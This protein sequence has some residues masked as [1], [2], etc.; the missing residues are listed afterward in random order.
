M[1]MKNVLSAVGVMVAV[2]LFAPVGAAAACDPAQD[3]V[4]SEFMAANDHTLVDEDGEF[5]D[6]IEVYNPCQPVVHLA[7]WS[8]TDDPDD[9]GKWH[10]PSVDLG[11]G[12]SVIV[13]A[14][15]KSRAVAGQPLH[16]NFKLEAAGEYLALVRPGGTVIA[17]EFAPQ[18]PPQV[19][20][21]SYGFEQSSTALLSKG[22]TAAWHV[23]AAGD[24][25][26]GSGWTAPAYDDAA[27]PAGPTG[28]GF[29]GAGS[30]GFDVTVYR[31]NIQVPDL[32]T[33]EAV[34]DDPATHA[35]MAHET[36]GVINYLNT[37]GS[38]HYG[39]DRT[40]PGMSIGTD[41]N[42]FVVLITGDVIIPAAGPW[43]FGVN[44]DDGFGLELSREPQLFTFSFP[45]PRGPADTLATFDLPEAGRYHL[46]LVMYERGGGSE[47]E[48]FAAQGTFASWTAGAF[49]LVGDTAAGGLAVNGLISEIGTDVGAAMRG[50]NASLWT[51]LDFNVPDPT[52]VGLLIL[53]LEYEDGVVAW[54]NGQQVAARNAPSPALWDSTALSDRPL[55]SAGAFER[56]DL[57]DFTGLLLPGTNVL[58]LQGLNN[59]AADP[60]FLVLPDLTS[61]GGGNDLGSPRFFTTPTPG[62]LNSAPGYPA[63][64]A[65]PQFSHPSA[66]FTTPFSLTLSSA[67]PAGV[68]RYTLDGSIPTATTGTVYTA[69][70][71]LSDSTRVTARVFEPG[72]APSRIVGRLYGRLDPSVTS[73][74]SNLPIV[75]VH[76]FGAA[77][78][79]DWLT[80]TLTS[81]I[82]TGAGGRATITDAA[83]F[84][85]PAGI[86]IRGSSSRSF[87][88]KQFALET[89]DDDH[90]DKDVAILDL[91]PESDWILY[92][93]YSEKGLIHN[94]MAYAWYNAL[95][96]YA[97]RTRFCELYLKTG[98][99]P[100]T[101]ADYAG[102]YVV[103][104]KIKLGP[105]RVNITELLPTDET[106]PAITGGYIIKKDRLDPGDSGFST[107]TGQVLAYVDPKE[108]EIT[109][110]QAAWL[111]GYLDQ[112]ESVLY[113]PGYADPVNGYA[114]YID[115]GS[116]IDHHILVELTKNI[117]GFRLSSFLSKDRLGKLDMGPI[118]D[119]N[120]SLGNANYLEGW[121]PTGWYHDMLGDGDYPYYRRLF[122]D[123]EFAQR[124]ADRWFELRRGP[125]SNAALLGSF[126]GA[127]ALLQESAPRNFQRWP[128]LGTYVWPNWYIGTTWA[129]DVAWTRQWLLDR[130]AWFDAQFPAPPA[131]S[132]PGG[133]VPIGTNLAITAAIGLIHYTLDGS[134]PRLPG[135]GVSPAAIVYSGPLVLTQPTHVRARSLASGVWSALNDAT[136]DPVPIAVVNEVL[137]VNLSTMADEHGDHDPWIEIYN[138]SAAVAALGGM[139]LTDDATIP[140]KWPIPAGTDLCGHERLLVWA[141]GEPSEGPLHAGFALSSSAGTISLF[142]AA[143][144][145]VNALARPALPPN[146]SYG[147]QPD[148]A[149]TFST[150]IH[151]TAATAN[152][153]NAAPIILNEYNGVLPTR[154]LSGGASDPYWGRILGNGGDWFELVV[155]QDHLDLRGFRVVVR[156]KAGIA[157]DSQQTLTFASN[158]ALSDLRSGTI[159]TVAADLM[160]D[161]SFNPSAGDFWINLRS[162]AS[163]DGQYI[164][165]LPFSVSNDNTQITLLDRDGVVVFGP[166]GEGINPASGVGNDEVLKLEADPGPGTT[167]A[168]EFRDGSSSTFGA[169]NVWSGG[170]ASQNFAALRAPLT[171][172]CSVDADCADGN[173]CTDD[174]C[175]GGHCVT[176]PNT[177]ACD[178]GN[179]C[180]GGDV[181]SGRVCRGTTVGSC[182]QSACAC[183]DSSVCTLDFCG[184]A[185]CQHSPVCALSGTV[186][187]YRDA[188]SVEPSA[189]G[190]PGVGIDANAD[191]IAD[192]LTAGGGVYAAGNWAG[193]SHVAPLS[194]LGA[195]RA[196]SENGA[197]SSFDASL[198]SRYA[199]QTIALSTNQKLAADVSGNGQVT[200]FDAARIAQFA[201]GLADHF[202]V[203]LASGSDWRFL[204]CDTYFNE[205]SHN[206]GAPLFTHDP[207][208]GPQ[209][210]DFYAVLFGDVSG[211]WQPT[212]ALVPGPQ[213]LDRGWTETGEQAAA[214]LDRDTA[215][216]RSGAVRPHPTRAPGSGPAVLTLEAAAG[217]LAR[218]ERRR[219]L[220]RID[221]ADGAEGIDLR[222]AYPSKRLGII[223]VQQAGIGSALSLA[224]GDFDGVLR[225]GLYGIEPLQGSGILV[226]ITIEAFRP[227]ARLPELRLEGTA[228]EGGIELVMSTPRPNR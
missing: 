60:D 136:Y 20:D 11:R 8:L 97:V 129:D 16:A 210:D 9:L 189:K 215:A 83:D 2:V 102:I 155:V 181:C 183:E 159:L 18:F 66:T 220:V 101:S 46:R 131:F 95:G 194:W 33:A 142:D 228:N 71:A 161:L 191:G 173:P 177:A 209:T 128:I 147:R 125:F 197:V 89:W 94:V 80:P 170:A 58:A 37:G 223:S 145:L 120:L 19:T 212:A 206:C 115:T 117:D 54:L 73:F 93:P 151:P 187:Y 34:I 160:S 57:T 185:G 10:F 166:A 3:L 179:P 38:A 90:K 84:T 35:S 104:E 61:V 96:R 108:V 190:V 14:S 49:D 154:L 28:L 168:S 78:A 63:V 203:A 175:V 167:A 82:D 64:S 51:R 45:Q 5:S 224:T 178:D 141:D 86:R 113:G 199:V 32:A 162:G 6:W 225:L 56:I 26:L 62:A 106:E 77:I 219:I 72:L 91:P 132:R 116:F 164:S 50:V 105:A 92:A 114:K 53:R 31:A 122:S 124:Y 158:A 79:E 121:L 137:P 36:A 85:G 130:L 4:I 100:V 22:A 17:Q 21:M 176:T 48:L 29:V 214:R 43:T 140:D 222:L 174:A 70:I 221:H 87:P 133:P 118:W 65:T 169:P 165:A 110:A 134:D 15:G 47:V 7:G 127:I 135:G 192:G 172:A 218:G 13:F 208:T 196:A 153:P 180:T 146:V 111:K 119:Y 12:E 217:R 138:P 216:R 139:F 152:Q 25:S 186:R 188:T 156:D 227:L 182:C 59:A 24:G 67:A 226:E 30:T 207:L 163:G 148:G 76:T 201:V 99:G 55:A 39:S 198:A 23:P 193:S 27:W 68:I 200:S 42:D 143:G 98:T 52:A 126:D 149:S 88:K 69:P 40:F 211:N 213:D 205:A 171:F 150:F 202:D 1:S 184:P 112:F 157:G 103:M 44:S 107:S 41:I 204:R 74:S 195:P 144:V 109:T 81:V 75:V 123:P